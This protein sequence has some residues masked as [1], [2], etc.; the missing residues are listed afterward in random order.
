M[1]ALPSGVRVWLATG[2][3]DMCK[4][5]ISLALQVQEVLRRDPH[6][7]HLC[8]F[9]GRWGDL[10]SKRLEWGRFLWP[11]PAD[12][13]V[14]VTL[15]Q[16]GYLLE[17]IDWWMPWWSWRPAATGRGCA[18]AAGDGCVSALAVASLFDIVSSDLVTAHTVILAER[19]ALLKGRSDRRRR[20][21]RQQQR[22]RTDL[23]AE[24]G[25][26][27][28]SARALWRAHGTQ[29][30]GSSTRWICSSRISRPAPTEVKL[31]AVAR[32]GNR[33]PAP[34]AGALALR[35]LP[36]RDAGRMR[37]S[38]RATSTPL[39]SGRPFGDLRDRATLEIVREALELRHGLLSSKLGKKAFTNLGVIRRSM[40]WTEFS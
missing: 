39:Q 11:S 12:G 37:G 5:F 28:I 19:A 25:D 40:A 4:G 20:V 27:E 30:L 15:A 24:A 22:G 33:L 36:L 10:F 32:A 3:T 26:R 31:V 21:G 7:G 23:A 38:R 18:H 17:G 1:I 13:V 2:D 8:V 16:L 6:G 14:T 29:D 34:T 9:R 35:E